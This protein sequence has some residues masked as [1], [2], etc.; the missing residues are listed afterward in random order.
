MGG[1]RPSGAR[2]KR[3]TAWSVRPCTPPRSSWAGPGPTRATQP[4]G[5]RH[6]R[7]R[8]E[9]GLSC[10]V[11]SARPT[12][13][14]RVDSLLETVARERNEADLLRRDRRMIERLA[15]IH[16]DLGVHL[17]GERADA[18][19]AAAFRATM[20]ST[21]TCSTLPMQVDCWPK[22][23][24]RSSWRTPSTSGL[25]SEDHRRPATFPGRRRLS[26]VAREADPDPW[27]TRLRETLDV[28]VTDRSRA[29][30]GLSRLAATADAGQ[31][32]EASVTRLAFALASWGAA[33]P[34]SPCSDG[35]SEPTPTISGSTW[36]WVENSR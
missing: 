19:Y 28:M 36:T 8:V 25:S 33:R 5:S 10:R 17:E 18:E 34:P 24:S 29:L 30:E 6:L 32:P 9:P 2:R 4:S 7:P 14:T 12:F 27:R 11:A 22:V 13:A 15:E 21:S 26:A 1:A 3:R 23:R 20:G 35:V 16:N 31:L